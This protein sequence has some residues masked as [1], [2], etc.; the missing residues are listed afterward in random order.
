MGHG[1]Q[2]SRSEVDGFSCNGKDTDDHAGVHEISNALHAGIRDG[3]DERR[4]GD[5]AAA[6]KTI[7]I[8]GDKKSD[9]DDLLIFSPRT[10]D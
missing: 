4:G 10:S 1:S 3:E 5:T 9:E 8:R 7:V 2:D 6:K